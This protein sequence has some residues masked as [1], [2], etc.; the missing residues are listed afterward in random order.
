M[1]SLIAVGVGAVGVVGMSGAG[2]RVHSASCVGEQS[3]RRISMGR[4]TVWLQ[5][6][7][8]T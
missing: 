4:M 5:R 2:C 3:V 1:S 6:E 8:Q 7:L